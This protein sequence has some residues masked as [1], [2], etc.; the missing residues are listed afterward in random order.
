MIEA[1]TGKFNLYNVSETKDADFNCFFS[2]F[3]CS[4][5]PTMRGFKDVRAKFF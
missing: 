4:D 3:R 5:A 1:K 2:W